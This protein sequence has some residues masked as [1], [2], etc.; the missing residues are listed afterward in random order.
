MIAGAI[1]GAS[2]AIALIAFGVVDWAEETIGRTFYYLLLAGMTTVLIV[3]GRGIDAIDV[4][5]MVVASIGG[6]LQPP[7]VRSFDT[8]CRSQIRIP[9][10][11][12]DGLMRWSRGRTAR[13]QTRPGGRGYSLAFRGIHT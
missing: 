7:V 10:F 4:A 9:V 1:L 5:I 2:F 8:D 11:G 6:L 13:K 12:G 3:D